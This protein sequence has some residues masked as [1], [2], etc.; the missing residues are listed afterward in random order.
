MAHLLQTDAD[1]RER[2]VNGQ[3]RRL[4]DFSHAAVA[5]RF[6]SYIDELL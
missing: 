3:N 5:A 2:I 6:K 4:A 1:L